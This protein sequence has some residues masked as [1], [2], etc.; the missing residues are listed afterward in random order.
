[1]ADGETFD[2]RKLTEKT[3]PETRR[4]LS[5]N[6]PDEMRADHIVAVELFV[7]RAVLLGKVDGRANGG[8][9]HQ[10]VG[11]ARDAD[12]DGARSRLGRQWNS[13]AVHLQSSFLKNSQP[14][15]SVEHG[16]M[17]ADNTKGRAW[18]STLA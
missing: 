13:S 8:D 7:D 16:S 1:M 12:R 2:F 14:E 9:Q 10:V 6:E 15:C 5:S 11:I 4:G 17:A 18:S 3:H